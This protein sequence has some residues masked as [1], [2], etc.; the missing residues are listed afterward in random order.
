ME[1]SDGRSALRRFKR[2]S[3]LPREGLGFIVT[4]ELSLT[5]PVRNSLPL[6]LFPSREKPLSPFFSTDESAD[7]VS[8]RDNTARRDS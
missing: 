6:S 3:A 1:I 2:C 5:L 7:R 4:E 8:I